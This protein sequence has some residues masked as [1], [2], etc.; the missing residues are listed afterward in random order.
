[1]SVR[2]NIGDEESANRTCSNCR[3]ENV[4]ALHDEVLTWVATYAIEGAVT[5]VI[6]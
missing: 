4:E 3:L 5:F 1:V 2:E 6:P